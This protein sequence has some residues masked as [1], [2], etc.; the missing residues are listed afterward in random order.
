MNSKQ[1]KKNKEFDI[2]FEKYSNLLTKEYKD[3]FKK[4]N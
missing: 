2:A 3:Q 1:S 4:S